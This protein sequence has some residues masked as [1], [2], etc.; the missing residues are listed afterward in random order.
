MPGLFQLMKIGYVV[1]HPTCS[2]QHIYEKLILSTHQETVLA[3]KVTDVHA[4]DFVT[5]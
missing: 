5:N 3:R 4:Q 2:Q 1:S